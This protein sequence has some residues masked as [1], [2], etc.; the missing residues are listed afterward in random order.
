L[1]VN[2]ENS[3][4]RTQDPA[5]SQKHGSADP[6][7][8]PKCHGSATLVKMSSIKE[9]PEEPWPDLLVDRRPLQ[10]KRVWKSRN[11]VEMERNNL[12]AIR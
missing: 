7:P 9:S 12:V 2:D 3:R 4:I 1:K 10:Q 8:P 11:P 6:D 5:T